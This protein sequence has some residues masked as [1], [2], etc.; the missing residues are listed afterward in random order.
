MLWPM[1]RTTDTLLVRARA[2]GYLFVKHPEGTVDVPGYRSMDWSALALALVEKARAGEAGIFD[3]PAE[4][5]LFNA[6]LP[7]ALKGQ[8]F[9]ANHWT[10]SVISIIRNGRIVR[11]VRANDTDVLTDVL[12]EL[13][14]NLDT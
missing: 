10:C 7:L 4:I 8:T 1:D 13:N 5:E 3:L 6:S 2:A 12:L 11:R 14:R 9:Q